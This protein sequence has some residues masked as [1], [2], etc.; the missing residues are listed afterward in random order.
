MLPP[1]LLENTSSIKEGSSG[2]SNARL[3]SR[4]QAV[5]LSLERGVSGGTF[6]SPSKIDEGRS[7]DVPLSD[8]EVMVVS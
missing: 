8:T 1:S 4:P 7:K 5:V 2:G 6:S 3:N